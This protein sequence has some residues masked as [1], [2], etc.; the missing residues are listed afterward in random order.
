MAELPKVL[1]DGCGAYLGTWA[2]VPALCPTCGAVGRRTVGDPQSTPYPEEW[3]QS[4]RER[5]ALGTIRVGPQELDF[6]FGFS[7]RPFAWEARAAVERRVE[8]PA[9]DA[10]WEDLL[11]YDAKIGEEYS[12]RLKQ[13]LET[14]VPGLRVR[15]GRRVG[16]E[17][18]GPGAEH[19][20]VAL[21][22][23]ANDYVGGIA[24]WAGLAVLVGAGLKKLTDLAQGQPAI[25][26]DGLALILASEAVLAA[27]GKRDLTLAFVTPMGAYPPSGDERP[28][29]DS[30]FVVGL[31]DQSTLFLCHV[32]PE[33]DARLLNAVPLEKLPEHTTD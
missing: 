10:P 14:A 15:T 20:L 31:R 28:S 26:S 2:S 30:G 25:V 21:F 1:C 22:G 17:T 13:E 12:L 27:T 32:T 29:E 5:A 19:D 11:E 8:A 3:A 24:N 18:G 4:Q 16:N 7:Y 23:L 33:G 9:N 6:Y